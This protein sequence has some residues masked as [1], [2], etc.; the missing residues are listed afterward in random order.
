MISVLERWDK[1]DDITE[2]P[3]VPTRKPLKNEEVIVSKNRARIRPDRVRK[4]AKILE[5]AESMEYNE[6]ESCEACIKLNEGDRAKREFQI[7][8]LDIT[9]DSGVE[10]E[11]TEDI[12]LDMIDF[13]DMDLDE[14]NLDEID[15]DV[16]DE[17]VMDIDAMELEETLRKIHIP[18]MI[19]KT[20]LMGTSADALIDTGA[21]VC[22]INYETYRKILAQNPYARLYPVEA[23]ATMA[24]GQRVKAA[25]GFKTDLKLGDGV[26]RETSFI[27]LDISKPMILGSTW[28]KE[29][30][31]NLKMKEMMF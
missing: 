28:M 18:N 14:I 9:E 29:N 17:P 26:T 12:D 7:N 24:N 2:K 21:N 22:A 10:S 16:I 20:E 4:E 30:G 15:F 19:L 11:A 6:S 31:V 3:E 8:A 5:E 13:D 27:V 23:T 25:G 1:I